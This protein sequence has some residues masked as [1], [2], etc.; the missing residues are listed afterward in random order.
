M[1]FDPKANAFAYLVSNGLEG[2]CLVYE[3]A[4]WVIGSF[5]SFQTV[6]NGSI[7]VKFPG[8][9]QGFLNAATADGQG[10]VY[11]VFQGRPALNLGTPVPPQ[12]IRVDLATWSY[13][14]Y[15]IHEWGASDDARSTMYP[16]S[17]LALD[18]ANNAA[19]ILDSY[20]HKIV[21]IDLGSSAVTDFPDSRIT[22][23]G[24]LILD[25]HGNLVADQLDGLLR[26]SPSGT[27]T[28]QPWP[29]GYEPGN[30]IVGGFP[31]RLLAEDAQGRIWSV[32]DWSS[33][34]A[35]MTDSGESSKFQDSQEGTG[36]WAW[37]EPRG[38]YFDGRS[39]WL[40]ANGQSNDPVGVL[41]EFQIQSAGDTSQAQV[42]TGTLGISSPMVVED[43]PVQLTVDAT[44]N[45]SLTFQWFKDAVQLPGAMSAT[46]AIPQATDFDQGSYTCTVQNHLF[47][48][49]ESTTLGP[50][51]LSVVPHPKIAVFKSNV[52]EIAKGGTVQLSAWFS[53]GIGR[54]EPG[55]LTVTS[56]IPVTVTPDSTTEY[57]LTV[58]GESGEL[59]SG[60][61][62]I[63]VDDPGPSLQAYSVSPSVVDLGQSTSLAWLLN[64]SPSSASL[65][66]DLG[67]LGPVDVTS[68]ST[69]PIAPHRRQ[70]IRLV[71]TTPS[72]QGSAMVKVAARGLESIAGL[73]GGAGYLDGTGDRARITASGAMAFR[74]DGSLLF[75]ERF[76]PE[77]RMVDAAGT[78]TTVAGR[79]NEPGDVDGALTDVR[80]TSITGLATMP[81]GSVVVADDK[82]LKLL[83]PPG[84]GQ[85]IRTLVKGLAETG[86]LCSGPDGCVYMSQRNLGNILKVTL[87]GVVTTY[88][89]RVTAPGPLT[90][91]SDGRLLVL[92]DMGPIC[93]IST[94][95]IAT[96]H[97][98]V[99]AAG[100]PAP[101]F[102]PITGI[103]RD[104]SDQVYVSGSAGVFSLDSTY[105]LHSLCH[106][107][108][109]E[110]ENYPGLAWSDRDGAIWAAHI[111]LGT[112]FERIVPG[113][114]PVRV[115]G[116][117]RSPV[118]QVKT[119]A[120][121]LGNNLCVEVRP[122][123]SL[124]VGDAQQ[125]KLFAV[126]AG[127]ALQEIPLGTLI[128][129]GAGAPLWTDGSGRVYFTVMGSIRRYDPAQNSVTPVM[130]LS[131]DGRFHDGDPGRASAGVITGMIGDREGGLYVVSAIN[132]DDTVYGVDYIRRITPGGQVITLVGG[133]AGFSD[134]QG[135][136]ALFRGPRG[137]A[138]DPQGNLVIADTWNHAIRRMTP[139][140][141]VTTITGF[142]GQGFLDG[143]ASQ[144]AFSWPTGVAVD[145]D[146][147]IFVA[148]QGNGAI[149][150]IDPD[151]QVSTLLGN[152][153]QPGAR[154]GDLGSAGLYQPVD[155]RIT[156][157]GDLIVSDRGQVFQLSAPRG[158]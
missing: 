16:Y 150:M 36:T 11:L 83:S 52:D 20:L 147:T 29:K 139:D 56:G 135:S 93:E 24:S 78:V 43:D 97:W 59:A 21:K 126:S 81:D 4:P 57:I 74:S 2:S 156:P 63:T 79:W 89:S 45:G 26:L 27:F 40:V 103:T 60:T 151:G 25:H 35:C 141:T 47:G 101:H 132:P 95:G 76:A 82:K 61:C 71:A 85:S 144:A 136:N 55:S 46:L 87:A 148:D 157:D 72:G 31:Q 117:M 145:T 110:L 38:M 44:G 66:D 134:G 98:P 68:I 49:T 32:S 34:V 10:H 102:A 50:K 94:D 22:F 121:T 133:Q 153:T 88:A 3:G 138:L 118:G 51:S 69:L 70:R 53:A 48:R 90:F 17:G 128:G 109:L 131:P 41:H 62:T 84:T 142:H 104:G 1:S 37:E 115:A 129:D 73:P 12:L 152:P 125:G 18:L 58:T 75:A 99:L 13:T 123:R 100:D 19:W 137:I 107:E 127:G 120:G 39:L 9:D 30:Y 146:G 119:P 149:R 113:Q 92:S 112:Q 42:P 54:I 114:A 15:T 158:K 124:L 6:V 8:L 143:D 108:G 105:S 65:Q 122:D 64:E 130:G 86:P 7:Q 140:G 5:G 67:F 154:D 111:G 80:F 155:I 96:E 14:R 106:L 28:L 116:L 33:V 23:N 91:L 77:L